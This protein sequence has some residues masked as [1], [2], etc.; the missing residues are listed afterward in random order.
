MDIWSKSL[1]YICSVLFLIVFCHNVVG[2]NAKSV[3]SKKATSKSYFNG[4]YHRFA[5][6]PK[7]YLIFTPQIVIPAWR[8]SFGSRHDKSDNEIYSS[9]KIDSRQ[10]EDVEGFAV[11]NSDIEISSP[12]YVYFD[13]LG[14]THEDSFLNTPSHVG[15]FV[16]EYFVNPALHLF[17]VDPGRATRR[18]SPAIKTGRKQERSGSGAPMSLSSYHRLK[19]FNKIEKLLEEAGADDG[20]SC[21][22]RAIC[23]L[24]E[25]PFDSG[26][27]G[28]FGEVL[29]LAFGSLPQ[30]SS[31]AA[32]GSPSQECLSVYAR[33]EKY[34]K[35]KDC[36][37]YFKYCKF[38]IFQWYWRLHPEGN[39]NI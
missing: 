31:E 36:A 35:A 20:R 14:W 33:A 38:S 12:F 25:F 22:L 16:Q 21:L 13:K 18:N 6:P 24:H 10:Y 11:E 28:F 37:R 15:S 17:G 34:G 23:E 32:N 4:F 3:N 30:Y 7:T 26:R 1:V 2:E 8:H 29:A 27:L 9:C 39:K 5:F 19:A